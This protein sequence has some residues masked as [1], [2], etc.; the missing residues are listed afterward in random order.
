MSTCAG[1]HRYASKAQ[2]KRAMRRMQSTGGGG[3]SGANVYRCPLCDGW[4]WGHRRGGS[5]KAR[6]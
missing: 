3:G 2:A 6:R 1:K 5:W 4:H